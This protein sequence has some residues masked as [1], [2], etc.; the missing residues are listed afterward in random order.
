MAITRQH[1]ID[2]CDQFL[3]NEIGKKEIEDF[4]WQAITSDEMDW[5]DDLISDILFE[6]DNEEIN[7]EINHHNME[8][9]KKRLKTDVDELLE[10]N[11]WNAHIEK[12][13]DIC[14][15]YNSKWNPVNKKLNIGVSS[16]LGDDPIN[17]LRH[18]A[19]KGTTGWFI[20]SGEYAENEDFFHPI[21]AE[22]LLQ[23]RPEI[24]KYLGLDIGYRFISDKN[25]YEDVWYDERLRT[26]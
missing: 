12:Q 10:H 25:G 22:H 18:P 1:L 19:E 11:Y 23:I 24:I 4:A 8:L 20:W 16:N 9:L 13:K 26:T 3:S 6:W 7:F 5:D 14:L 2:L 15:K 21:C 17:G